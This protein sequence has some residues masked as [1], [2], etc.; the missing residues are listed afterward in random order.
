MP[1]LHPTF[2]YTP[3]EI[4]LA[5]IAAPFA[6]AGQSYEAAATAAESLLD[7]CRAKLRNDAA[8]YEQNHPYA[9]VNLTRLRQLVKRSDK[10]L[11]SYVLEAAGFLDKLSPEAQ[12]KCGEK[13]WHELLAGKNV[14]GWEELSRI[15][16]L[17]KERYA[18]ARKKRKK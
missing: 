15:Q 12:R 2:Q 6:A 14:L 8:Y 17:Q 10:T 16:Q 13:L 11:R 1:D 18:T 5:I 3:E 7:A 9:P 4:R